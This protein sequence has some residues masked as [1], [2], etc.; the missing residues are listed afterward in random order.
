M[1]PYMTLIYHQYY[2]CLQVPSLLT[3][4]AKDSGRCRCNVQSLPL[5]RGSHNQCTCIEHQN[6]SDQFEDL[7]KQRPKCVCCVLELIDDFFNMSTL[8]LL[9]PW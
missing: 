4:K 3:C 1:P 9:L 2:H 5:Q 6:I 7:K 8:I